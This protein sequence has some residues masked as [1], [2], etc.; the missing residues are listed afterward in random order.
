MGTNL[1]DQ[2]LITNTYLANPLN[3]P[4]YTDTTNEVIE[5]SVGYLSLTDILGPAQAKSSVQALL[6][7]AQGRAE[8][9]VQKGGHTN[10]KGLAQQLTLQAKSMADGAPVV[11]MSFAVNSSPGA[12]ATLV[13][14]LLPQR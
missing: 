5:G 6:A 10:A 14:N 1:Q 2:P 13:W 4:N 3:P 11:E 9:F 8:A 12:F 7:S